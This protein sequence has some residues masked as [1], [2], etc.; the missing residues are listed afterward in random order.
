MKKLLVFLCA[1]SLVFGVAR[2]A[3]AL[4]SYEFQLGSEEGNL[5]YIDTDPI[6]EGLVMWADVYNAV[7]GYTFNLE[8]GE[9]ITFLFGRIGT[10]ERMI[11]D[12]ILA[13]GT[14]IANISFSN[15][16]L[17]EA[18]EGAA[19]GSFS[20][21]FEYAWGWNLTWEDPHVIDFGYGGQFTLALNDASWNSG[22]WFGCNGE[23]GNAY[24]D[25]YATVTLNSAPP[26]APE[27]ATMLLF[28]SGLIGL[29]AL[30]RKKFL[31]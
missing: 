4:P 31:K 29:A 3:A 8:E 15:P 23:Y 13:T 24:A 21:E 2:I 11:V 22:I 30:G 16:A 26:H 18:I 17:L 27:P 28:G 1:M 20:A 6:T 10:D 5:S 19:A 25:V 14:M 9:S 7:H 12:E